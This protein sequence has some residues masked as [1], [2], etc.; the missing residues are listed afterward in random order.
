VLGIRN[1]NDWLSKVWVIVTA[2][3]IAVQMLL[4]VIVAT[5]MAVAAPL[6][7]FDIC[8]SDVLAVPV[9][10]DQPTQSHHQ[11]PC[12]ICAFASLSPPLPI[13]AAQ[14]LMRVQF[15]QAANCP[16][17]AAAISRRFF[18]PRTS[19]GPPQIL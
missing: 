12:S 1:R 7:A 14:L 4:G 16:D 11:A 18:G 17:A 13:Q 15:S 6:G 2:Y 10:T 8:N 9:K 3:L 19:Q 5:Q